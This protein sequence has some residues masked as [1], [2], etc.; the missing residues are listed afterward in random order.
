M[1][2][3]PL[4]PLHLIFLCAVTPASFA[5]DYTPISGGSGGTWFNLDCGANMSLVG[6]QGKAGSLIDSVQGVCAQFNADGTQHGAKVLTGKAG[7]T[8]GTSYYM[9]CLEGR[10]VRAIHGKAGSYI[11]G[12]RLRCDS[13]DTF[14]VG[15]LR[16]GRFFWANCPNSQDARSVRGRAGTWVDA[17][18]LGCKSAERLGVR[19][20]SIASPVRA[21][22]TA[23]LTVRTS[24]VPIE[25][26]NVRLNSDNEALLPSPGV[27]TVG[28]TTTS[29]SSAVQ[30]TTIGCARITASYKG[31]SASADLV[32]HSVAS[33][34]LS[35]QGPWKMGIYDTVTLTASIPSSSPDRTTIYV[36]V[37]SSAAE[38]VNAFL[39]IPPN[40]TSATFQVR[41]RFPGGCV[42]VHAKVDKVGGAEVTHTILVAD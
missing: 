25:S 1:N 8:G 22:R 26:M 15:S 30:A 7:G 34:G 27:V 17:I 24:M 41:G 35:L 37:R 42:P 20:I 3:K 11:N 18:G 29:A 36:G 21:G 23:P 32:V 9:R 13:V 40:A 6:I 33:P 5:T 19:S 2:G 10:T 12:M 16:E 31:S 4:T 28:N 38:V 39:T 14:E